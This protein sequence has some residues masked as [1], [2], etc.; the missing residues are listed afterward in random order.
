MLASP[1][2][3]TG[4]VMGEQALSDIITVTEELG[5]A[6]IMDEIYSGLV[7]D[8]DALSAAGRGDHVLVVSSF[9]KYHGLTGLRTGWLVAP[10]RYVGIAEKLAQ[11][12]FLSAS[13][14]G[15]YG[16]LAALSESALAL[17]EKR[18]KIME[19]R[20]K[21]LIQTLPDL[22]FT[23]PTK[24]QGAF[25]VYADCSALTDNSFVFCDDLLARA[26]VVITPGKDFGDNQ[27]QR[28]VRFSC[29]AD[30]EQ[31]REGMRRLEQFLNQSA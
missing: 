7:Y 18:R 25:Y 27:P 30:M 29:T 20:L 31:L 11:N 19:E 9:S 10:Q 5:G 14:P 3:P 15:Q 13:T 4:A 22:G 6:L 21:Y 24:P 17:F 2:N 26:G 28:H 1:A 23:L 8:V 16:A 12:L